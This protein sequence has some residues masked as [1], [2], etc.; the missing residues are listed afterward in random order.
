[1]VRLLNEMLAPA[2]EVSPRVALLESLLASPHGDV[3]RLLGLHRRVI[4]EDARFYTHLAAWYAPQ[5]AL[6]DHL[7]LLL[8]E[9]FR[10][11]PSQREAA[12][13]LLQPLRTF[14][15]ARLMRHLKQAHGGVTRTFRTA[16]ERWLRRREAWRAWWEE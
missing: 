2:A 14:Q 6:R 4:E 3:Q 5:G 13:V 7:T 1:M 9:L 12:F 8:G 15:V 10:G 11:S 16:V